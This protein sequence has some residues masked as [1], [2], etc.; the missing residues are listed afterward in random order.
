[1][2]RT[3]T[4]SLLPW[5][6]ACSMGLAAPSSPAP[7]PAAAADLFRRLAGVWD[8]TLQ[9]ASDGDAPPQILNGTDVSTVGGDG[10]WLVSDFRSQ[11][12]GQAFQGH[13]ILTWDAAEGHFHR[14]WADASS[15]AF[16]VSEGSFDA[17]TGSLT[18]WIDSVDSQGHAVRWREVMAMK[19]ADTRTFT[20]YL[21]GPETTE[22]AG[23]TIIYHRRKDG[24]APRTPMA[25]PAAAP[26]D[27]EHGLVARSAGTWKTTVEDRSGPKGSTEVTKGTET[28]TVCCGALFLL[29][30]LTGTTGDK[31]Y[32]GHGL[33]GY[34]PGSKSYQSAWIDTRDRRLSIA[35]GAYDPAGDALTFRPPLPPE[36]AGAAAWREVLLWKGTDQRTRT[37]YRTP[38]N[39]AEVAGRTTHYKRVR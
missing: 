5:I 7:Q 8:A 28:D 11:L 24:A 13:G 31:P 19:D 23:M 3:R 20:M 16:W 18:M 26:P 21:P 15:P 6:A 37:L 2:A 39:G 34:D 9:M 22:A 17:P 33:I 10:L 38:P 36:A 32:S 25:G 30:D 12:E 14:V 1:M 35:R 27:P 29:T 4:A